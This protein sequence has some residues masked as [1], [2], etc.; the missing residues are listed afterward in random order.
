[1][2]SLQTLP[3]SKVL[4]KSTY[5]SKPVKRELIDYISKQLKITKPEE[6]YNVSPKDLQELGIDTFGREAIARGKNENILPLFK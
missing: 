4:K 2:T 3:R 6:W 1:M 5:S